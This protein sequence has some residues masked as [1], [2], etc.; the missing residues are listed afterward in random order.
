MPSGAA[1][2]GTDSHMLAAPTW[3]VLLVTMTNTWY[4]VLLTYTKEGLKSTTC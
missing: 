1:A 2:G 4:T 3:C